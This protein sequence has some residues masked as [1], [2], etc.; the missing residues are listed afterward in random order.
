MSSIPTYY[1]SVFKM[2]VWVAHK[3]ERLQRNFFWSDCLEK[4]KI[5]TV[6]WDK[7]CKSKENGGLG[8]GSIL[9]KN[10][11]LLAKWV[12]RFGVE[13]CSLWKMVVCAKYRIPMKI[14]KWD[15]CCGSKG[16]AFIKTIAGLFQQDTVYG[17]LL[18]EGFVVNVGREDRARLWTD[19]K[20]EGHSLKE[21]FPRIHDL[22]CDKSGYVSNFGSWA[23]TT[24]EWDVKFRRPVFNWE[25]QQWDI[26]RCCLDNYKVQNNV[27]DSI[28]WT[29][30]S[31]G[32]ITVKSF[33]QSL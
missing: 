33:W 1:M 15:W 5:H 3:L 22:A 7:M 8:I 18:E 16:S 31:S 20:V 26:F 17:N 28:G 10:K 27:H 21:A 32:L 4:K 24:W 9:N 6:K 23:G 19:L 11:G 2:P 12:W 30:D 29:F 13:E 14:L 25:V